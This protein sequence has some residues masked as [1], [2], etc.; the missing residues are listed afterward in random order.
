MFKALLH[1][2]E[3]KNNLVQRKFRV[4]LRRPADENWHDVLGVEAWDEGF[5][6]IMP[7]YPGD[8]PLVARVVLDPTHFIEVQVQPDTR[9]EITYK[10]VPSCLVG[11][12][13]VAIKADDWDMLVRWFKGEPLDIPNVGRDEIAAKS[14]S[15]DDLLRIMPKALLTRVLQQLVDKERLAPLDPKVEPL[16][17]YRYYG[18][19]KKGE[20]TFHRLTI[21]SKV[22]RGDDFNRFSTPVQINAE[23]GEVE[24]VR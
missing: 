10:D 11:M 23:S 19:K 22:V 18:T 15:E 5:S 13:F 1:K 24:L 9:S 3:P 17:S 21:D 20:K 7:R 6:V 16:V 12:K 8:S 14:M 2:P 4:Q